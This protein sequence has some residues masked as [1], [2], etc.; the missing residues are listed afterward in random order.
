MTGRPAKYATDAERLH[1]RRERER[2]RYSATKRGRYRQQRPAPPKP[3]PD[4]VEKFI[5]RGGVVE[6]LSPD[7]TR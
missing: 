1:A 3:E 5:A 4:T 6:T 7:A 2:A